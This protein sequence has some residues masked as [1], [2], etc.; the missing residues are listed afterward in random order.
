MLQ[1]LKYSKENSPHPIFK[2]A[3]WSGVGVWGHSMGGAAAPRIAEHGA[4][5]GINVTAMV[6]SHGAGTS[7]SLENVPS[8]FTT[9]TLDT[10]D[11]DDDGNKNY[12]YSQYKV[13]R[14]RPK[15]FVNLQDGY[16]MEPLEGKRL[17]YLTAQ[18]FACHVQGDQQH[19]NYIDSQVCNRKDLAVCERDD[20]PAPSPSPRP[21]PTPTPSP[22][23]TP[24]NCGSF[25]QQQQCKTAGC[26]WCKTSWFG[27]CQASC[28]FDETVSV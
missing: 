19:C 28:S 9:G 8:L 13:C 23:P 3:D 20:S 26:K 22:S 17:N 10:K 27:T 11:H 6:G 12:F 2:K 15:Y 5:Y 4:E 16:H 21:S 7:A 18:F 24:T 25:R 14:G 1:A